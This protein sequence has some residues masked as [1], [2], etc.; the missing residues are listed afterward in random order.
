MFLN[1]YR[2]GMILT[3]IKIALK[4]IQQDH[5][6][7]PAALFGAV[8]GAAMQLSAVQRIAATTARIIATAVWVS[9]WPGA[10]NY[11]FLFNFLYHKQVVNIS[12]LFILLPWHLTLV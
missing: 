4:P 2:T 5:Q 12:C 9:A 6:A 8:A 11:F 7:A 3:T 10:F 1:G